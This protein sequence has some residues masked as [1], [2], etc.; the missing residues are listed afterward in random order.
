MVLMV[1]LAELVIVDPLE[2]ATIEV[3]EGSDLLRPDRLM[4][5]VLAAA[6]NVNVGGLQIAE[7]VA[8]AARKWLR[9]RLHKHVILRHFAHAAVHLV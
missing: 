4:T 2:D 7:L 9:L 1:A 8:A 5:A 6:R 3:I